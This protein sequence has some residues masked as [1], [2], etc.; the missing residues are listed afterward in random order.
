MKG[1][2]CM[3]ILMFN[4]NLSKNSGVM[5]VIMNYYRIINNNIQ[6]DFLVERVTL[7]G[8]THLGVTR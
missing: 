1:G 5:N 2:L 7:L 3:R 4:S 8:V 6:F